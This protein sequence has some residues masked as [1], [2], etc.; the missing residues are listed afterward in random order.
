MSHLYF[1]GSN[2]VFN[3][4]CRNTIARMPKPP[5]FCPFANKY[6]KNRSGTLAGQE[7]TVFY[8]GNVSFDSFDGSMGDF[9][10]FGP[11]DV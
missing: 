11:L 8:D 4:D 7:T 3:Y 2:R 1:Y 9:A 10:L 6:P 5:Y